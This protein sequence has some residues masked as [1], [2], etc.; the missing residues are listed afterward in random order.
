MSGHCLIFSVDASLKS[1]VNP[2]I[3]V[4]GG[5]H[6]LNCLQRKIPLCLIVMLYHYVYLKVKCNMQLFLYQSIISLLAE[7]L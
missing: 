4:L 1:S 6:Y 5:I 2:E 3:S 7:I